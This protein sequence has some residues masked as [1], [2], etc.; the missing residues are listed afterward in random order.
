METTLARVHRRNQHA[1]R[2]VGHGTDGALDGDAHLFQR[3]P[4]D[5]KHVLAEVREDSARDAHPDKDTYPDA[6]SHEAAHH[7][8]DSNAG[9]DGDAHRHVGAAAYTASDGNTNAHAEDLKR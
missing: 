6:D 1:P 8:A 3:L 2:W 7:D 4:Q 5:F 9:A